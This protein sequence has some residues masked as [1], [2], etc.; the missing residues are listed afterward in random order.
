LVLVAGDK[1]LAKVV[2]ISGFLTE[3]R[4][5]DKKI[6]VNDITKIVISAGYM[7]IMRILGRA[8]CRADC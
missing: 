1:D 7:V 8:L 5:Q 2:P 3:T 6:I 4:H